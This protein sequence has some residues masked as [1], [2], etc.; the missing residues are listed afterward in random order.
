M[1]ISHIFDSHWY[2]LSA[3]LLLFVLEV[4]VPGAFLM[5]IGLGA[6]MVGVFILFFPLAPLGVLLV[7]LAISVI[8]AVLLGIYF[9]KKRLSN[10][11]ATLVQGLNMYIGRQ[12]MLSLAIEPNELVRIRIDDTFFSATADSSLKAGQIVKVKQVQNNTLHLEAVSIE[13]K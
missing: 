9:Q 7:V 2:W 5:W 8:M 6:A 1:T 4:I 10:Q 12:F 13:Q 3:A 11:G